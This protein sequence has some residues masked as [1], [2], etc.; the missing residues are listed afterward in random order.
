MKNSE[1]ISDFIKKLVQG[2]MEGAQASFSTYCTNKTKALNE[3]E[4]K[5][6]ER[7]ERF[8][9]FK[10]LLVEYGNEDTPLRMDGDKI[11][12]NNKE[13]GHIEVDLNDFESGINFVA[14][15]GSFSKEFDTA[16]D[17]FA[18]LSQK[19]LGEANVK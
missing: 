10:K 4:N 15:D 9:Q 2:D 3:G 6:L 19:Y 1:L 17:L 7:L 16:E 11:I 18:F 5:L 8:N 12:V 13:V 14:A